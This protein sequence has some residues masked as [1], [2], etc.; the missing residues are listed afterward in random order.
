LI[1]G[2]RSAINRAAPA[3]TG[4]PELIDHAAATINRLAVTLDASQAPINR[5]AATINRAV[6]AIN[7]ASSHTDLA[8]HHGDHKPIL[9]DIAAQSGMPDAFHASVRPR[10]RDVSGNRYHHCRAV[11]DHC[12]RKGEGSVI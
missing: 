3:T 12:R 9:A 7:R 11:P 6:R 2:A 10:V 4:A 1:N 5:A 8:T